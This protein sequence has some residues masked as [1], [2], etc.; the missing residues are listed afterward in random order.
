MEP[1]R[2]KR[3]VP[4]R[5]SLLKKALRNAGITQRRVAAEAGVTKVTVCQ[6]LGGHA[7][8]ANVVRTAER[9]LAEHTANASNYTP[10]ELEILSKSLAPGSDSEPARAIMAAHGVTLVDRRERRG[11]R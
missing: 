3:R 11:E 9:L 1:N 6:V 5:I 10:G 2:T 4:R 7:V 8:S